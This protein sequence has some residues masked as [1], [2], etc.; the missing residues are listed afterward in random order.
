MWLVKRWTTTRRRPPGS[1]QS[2]GASLLPWIRQQE[3]PHAHDQ[4]EL[5][6]LVDS[7]SR[8]NVRAQDSN[9]SDSDSD[10]A[11]DGLG[12]DDDD[13]CRPTDNRNVYVN[14]REI[15][16][17][18]ECGDQ[19]ADDRKTRSTLNLHRKHGGHQ[20]FEQPVVSLRRRSG[21][22]HAWSLMRTLIVMAIL[23]GLG[24][25][26]VAVYWLV[27]FVSLR[28]DAIT[29]S[30]FSKPLEP[31]GHDVEHLAPRFQ[32]STSTS[33][34]QAAEQ[35]QSLLN[36]RW[37][38][39]NLEPCN[40]ECTMSTQDVEK[41]TQELSQDGPVLFAVN[42]FNSQHV[43]PTIAQSL[44]QVAQVLGSRN[45]HVSVFENGS[46]DNTAV[47]LSHFAAAL[48]A[49]GV[50]HTI[51]SDPRSTDWS[52]V[53]RI[54]QLALYRNYVLQP[55][56]RTTD[57]DGQTRQPFKH[58]VF[59]NDVFMC[60]R[61]A[62]ELLWQRKHQQADAACAMDWRAT[63]SPLQS[64][65]FKK[66][67]KFYDN[68][69]SRDLNGNML[70][71]RLDVFAELRDGVKELF[72]Q[73]GAEAYRE[74]FLHGLPVPVYSCWNGMLALPA[75]PFQST[76]EKPAVEFRSA[77]NKPGQCAA[78]ECKILAKDFWARGLQRWLIIPSVHVTY[79]RDTYDFPQLVELKRKS[80][81]TPPNHLSTD[82]DWT[83]WKGPDSVI[84]WAWV[85]GTTF[86]FPWRAQRNAP[87][88]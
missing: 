81:S 52:K 34:T 72:D 22:P 60:A 10:N 53:D 77:F 23:I 35:V 19:A 85:R 74:R 11:D 24:L 64:L 51:L 2:L 68:W 41:Y 21:G 44:L 82:V 56:N 47:A 57:A 25:A 78:S 1:S 67:V 37:R 54:A 87:W 29:H 7:P 40:L 86:D 30:V 9:Q 88:R 13:F 27:W 33:P 71:A 48:T 80:E 26:A 43:L 73:P 46:T 75:A 39:L 70:R 55:I 4:D 16:Y 61:D 79:E 66:G 5:Q 31:Q 15:R 38:Q 6:V 17:S 58:V 69:V 14:L 12:G 50:E 63:K 49:S 28:Q 45:V 20:H 62:L 76:P 59:I 65:G 42:L 8:W 84:C 83:A 36:D 32:M 3:D 18:K